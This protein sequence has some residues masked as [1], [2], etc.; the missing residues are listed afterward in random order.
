M[1][2]ILRSLPYKIHIFL[3]I[4]CLAAKELRKSKKIGFTLTPSKSSGFSTDI[5]QFTQLNSPS[6][7]YSSK[8]KRGELQIQVGEMSA[9]PDGKPIIFF[10]HDKQAL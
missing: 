10:T 7:N 2:D 3:P 8:W 5:T 6:K 4:P 1:R 9:S